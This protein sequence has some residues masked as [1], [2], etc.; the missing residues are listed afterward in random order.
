MVMMINRITVAIL[1]ILSIVSLAACADPELNNEAKQAYEKVLDQYREVAEMS[2]EEYQNRKDEFPLVCELAINDYHYMGHIFYGYYDLNGD[3]LDE[4]LIGS[5]YEQEEIMNVTEEDI[6]VYHDGQVYSVIDERFKTLKNIQ[7]YSSM[8]GPGVYKSGPGGYK[9]MVYVSTSTKEGSDVLIYKL[10]K[11]GKE[12]I[13]K[14]HYHC[15]N[16]HYYKN[17]KEI[18]EDYYP[19]FRPREH[20]TERDIPYEVLI[21]KA[22]E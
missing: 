17:N 20:F 18:L 3:G 19:R 4:L 16:G 21:E 8:S 6:L 22:K 13:L 11:E 2:F 10:D 15:E 1:F 9:N 5:D 7:E 14:K 12:L